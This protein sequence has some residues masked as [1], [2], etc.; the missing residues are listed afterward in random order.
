MSLPVYI[1]MDTITDT[2]VICVMD[3]DEDNIISD[4]KP[5]RIVFNGSAAW[6]N[7]TDLIK[8]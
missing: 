6:N 2:T 3:E 5:P 1:L 7:Y 4:E 8:K